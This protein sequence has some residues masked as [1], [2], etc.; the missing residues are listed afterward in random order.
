MVYASVGKGFRPGGGNVFLPAARCTAD[1]GSLG[2]T[3]GPST[4]NSDQL[5][6]Y[7]IGTK[8]DALHRA[9]EWDASAFYVK[10][11]NIQSLVL[12][13][14]CGFSFVGNLGSA[15]SK[16]FD[17]QVNAEL[18]SRLTV[19][20]SLAYTDARYAATVASATPA[21][22]VSDG[23][24]LP[25]APWHG[26]ASIDYIAFTLANDGKGYLHLDGQYGSPY[27]TGNPADALYDPVQS[28]YYSSTFAN[29]R[30]GVRRNGWDVSLFVRNLTNSHSV[31]WTIHDVR[32]SEL[33]YNGTFGPRSIG[34]T[35]N[36][37]F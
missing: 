10:W 34:V 16:G 33:R 14:D 37:Q 29:L 17:L 1:L 7:E 11:N 31:L 19:G 20:A 21:P 8:G 35:A 13:P 18:T 26:T 25:A 36:Y 5:W 12:L 32:T 4:Y 3:Q 27:T 24:R 23:D 15:V 6:S 2:L 28:K 9:V 30:A 22:L